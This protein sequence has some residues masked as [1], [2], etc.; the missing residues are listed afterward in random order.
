MDAI[1]GRHSYGKR[2]IP[3]FSRKAVKRPTGTTL[4]DSGA[5]NR[6]LF[7]RPGIVN[8]GAGALEFGGV[9]G[10]NGKPVVK[11][12]RGNEEIGLRVSY[13]SS[14]AFFDHQAPS[15]DNILAD[16][17]RAALEHG[18]Y[19]VRQ[20]IGEI[21]PPNRVRDNVNAVTKLGEADVADK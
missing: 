11:G 19:I 13:A 2:A 4:N 17:Q 20:P 1:S 16:G 14:S 9:A 18:S 6:Q 8:L 15:H 21:A 10:D 12:R 7:S 5:G 3:C